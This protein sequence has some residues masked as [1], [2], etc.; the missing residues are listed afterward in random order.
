[1]APN[2]TWTVRLTVKVTASIGTLITENGTVSEDT[3]DP[4][5]ANSMATVST[6]VE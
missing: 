5:P 4:D 1:M 3:P 6:L 2:T